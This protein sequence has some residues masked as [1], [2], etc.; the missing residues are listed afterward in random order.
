MFKKLFA[1]TV[2]TM[3]VSFGSSLAADLASIKGPPA[4]PPPPPL[5]TGLYVGIN[6]GYGGGNITDS[7]SVISLR[8]AAIVSQSSETNTTRTGGALVGGQVGYNYELSNRF[9]VGGEVDMDWADAKSVS[10]GS[11]VTNFAVGQNFSGSA[12]RIGLNWL[13]TAR[14]RVG[15][16]LGR[17][18]PYITGGL[19]FGELS[20]SNFS[21]GVT[22]LIG[23]GFFD[24]SVGQRSTT[25]VG[26]A[27]G[28]GAEYLFADRWSL[29]V[30]YL[31]T[32]LPGISRNEVGLSVPS[33]PL[34]VSLATNSTSS[35][36]TH[37]VRAGLN[38]HLNLFVPAPVVA[39]Y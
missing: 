8:G 7:L 19:A 18:L 4:P 31:F 38:Y 29:K 16:D 23:F 1:A 35:F 37:S 13:G 26:W 22:R 30:E 25:N 15:Y 10:Y 9:V 2:T 39:A 5:W 34:E 20:S 6:G 21:H 33:L 11:N 24:S 32:Q 3:A 28:V 17:L 14:L 12:S 36:N 27:A